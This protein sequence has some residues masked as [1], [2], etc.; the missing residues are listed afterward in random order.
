MFWQHTLLVDTFC[1]VRLG[2][3]KIIVGRDRIGKQND[4]ASK[5]SNLLTFYPLGRH[6]I[7]DA[8]FDI[9][10]LADQL[11]QSKS[12]TSDGPKLGKINFSKNHVPNL[13]TQGLKALEKNI[14]LCNKSVDQKEHGVTANGKQAFDKEVQELQASEFQEL[15]RENKRVNDILNTI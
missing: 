5:N 2:M 13:L 8:S 7:K 12:T 6:S 11:Y 9:L 1:K 3:N 14:I 4:Q 15:D 10:S